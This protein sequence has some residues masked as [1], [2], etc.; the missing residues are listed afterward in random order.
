M[1]KFFLTVGLIGVILRLVLMLITAHPDLWAFYFTNH[2]F[3]YAGIFNIYDYLANLSKEADLAKNYGTNFFTYPPLAYFLLGLL[4]FIL[5]PLGDSSFY[6]WAVNH[7]P[8]IYGNV[9]VM[10]EIFLTKLP[11]LF[12]DVGVAIVLVKLFKSEKEKKLAFVLWMFN[13]LT[14]YSS[15]MVGQFDILPIFFVVAALYFSLKKK[16]TLAVLMLGIGGALKMFPLLFLPFFIFLLG[17]NWR[18]KVMLS[19]LG[20]LPYLL[21][22][23]PFL[24]STAFRQ[25]SLFASQSQK[26]LHMSLPVSG[27]EGIYVFVLV[28]FFLICL[29]AFRK[30]SEIWLFCLATMLLFFSVTHYHPQWMLW[31]TPFFVIETVSSKFKHFW[32]WLVLFLSWVGITLMFEPSLNFA[33]F[34]PLSPN[35]VNLPG[36][37]ESISPFYNVFQLK[38]LLRSLFAGVS[39]FLIYAFFVKNQNSKSKL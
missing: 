12:F 20:A 35:L 29:A 6:G 34:A 15:F 19:I 14:L 36:L 30:T 26:M 38:S 11:Y 2:L 9:L 5:R 3:A 39:L 31:L 37:S 21:S 32:L 28:Y 13:P 8:M 10:K 22:I 4:S 7:Y 18:E 23:M 17:R 25:V 16:A 24:G 27:A 33:L 1:K